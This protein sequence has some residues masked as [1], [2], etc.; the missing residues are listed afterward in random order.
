MSSGRASNNRNDTSNNISNTLRVI[1]ELPPYEDISSNK[2]RF[3]L[4]NIN[5]NQMKQN[6]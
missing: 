5:S 3:E 4:S 6:R 1:T 2:Y